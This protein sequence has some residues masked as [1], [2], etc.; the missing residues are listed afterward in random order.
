VPESADCTG[1]AQARPDRCGPSRGATNAPETL[2]ATVP[3]G[4]PITDAGC[5]W[6]L[7]DLWREMPAC[8][9]C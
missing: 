4:Q 7:Q 9:V 6:R 2:M 1:A 5:G 3:F 8:G